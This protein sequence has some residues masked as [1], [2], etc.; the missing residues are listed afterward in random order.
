MGINYNREYIEWLE[1]DEDH[2]GED[3]LYLT[4]LG[5]EQYNKYIKSLGLN[6]ENIKDKGI[7]LDYR[8]CFYL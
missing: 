7:L 8:S 6:Y 1:L 2:F 5:E 3:Y 4:V